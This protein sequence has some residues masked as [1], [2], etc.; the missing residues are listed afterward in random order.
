[1]STTKKQYQQCYVAFLDILGF[2]NR[3]STA[4]CDEI[5]HA[6]VKMQTD[7]IKKIRWAEKDLNLPIEQVKT[8]ILSDS[9]VYYIDQDIPNAFGALLIC[10][11]YMIGVLAGQKQPIFFRGGIA[12]GD[13]FVED[14]VIF[15][16]AMVEAY[17]MESR[18][19]VD[20]RIIILPEL[21]KDEAKKCPEI[22]ML[23]Y[24]DDDECYC[25]E[26]ILVKTDREQKKKVL[27]HIQEVLDT[28]RDVRVRQKY[29]YLKKYY[30]KMDILEWFA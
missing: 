1:M 8:Q 7:E 2:K 17:S 10:C 4:S 20:P 16:P 15:G 28:T 14:N 19:A 23:C 30:Q 3:I 11:S 21:F 5:Y 13:I 29:L 9:I 18:M 22:K 6:F 24:K 27:A 12:K 25:V 26:N